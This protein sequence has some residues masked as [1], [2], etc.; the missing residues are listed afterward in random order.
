MRSVWRIA[1]VLSLSVALAACGGKKGYMAPIALTSPV[2]GTSTVDMLIATTRLPSGDPNTL[3]S[4]ERS[5]RPYLTELAVSIPPDS[6]RKAGQVQWPKK[7][8]PDPEKDFAVTKVRQLE[9]LEGGEEW[10]RVHNKDGH[11]MVFVHGF[12]NRYE[13]AVFRFAQIVH[14]SGAVV[15]PILFTW[16]SRAKVFDY[17]YDKESTNYSRTGLE[18]LLKVLEQEKGVKDITILAHSMG[19]WLAMEALRQMAIRDGR[20]A[21]KIENVVLASPDIDIDVFARQWSD[22][23]EKKPNI[24]IFVSQDDKALALSRFIS[25]DVQRLGQVN[26]AEEPYRAQFEKAGITVVD[27]TK[28]KSEDSLNHGKFAESPE[29][30]KLI[31]NR[32]VNGQTLTDSDVSLGEGITAVVAGTAGGIGRIAATT[33]ATPI[34]LLTLTPQEQLLGAGPD[35]GLVFDQAQETKAEAKKQ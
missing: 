18:R 9:S 2:A 11:V 33:V 13:D 35:T 19:T 7:L 16:P 4:G 24:T 22:L 10:F 14:D 27:L 31:G 20:V 26:P 8:P 29:I 28:V 5:A 6:K 1:V 34:D 23:G 3:F 15:T 21:A 25:G 17:N 12:N 32:L 30:V